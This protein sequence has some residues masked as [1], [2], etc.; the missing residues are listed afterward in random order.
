MSGRHGIPAGWTLSGNDEGAEVRT[1]AESEGRS[2]ITLSCG[3]MRGSVYFLTL[4][5]A[6]SARRHLSRSVE[7]S[8]SLSTDEVSGWAGLWMRVDGEV[9]EP[10]LAFD[11][12]RSRAL[13]G[14][15]PWT[16]CAVVLP[17]DPKARSIHFGLMLA[18][19]GCIRARGLSFRNTSAKSTD[20]HSSLPYEPIN[21]NFNL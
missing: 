6:I 8:A 19:Q 7:F 3:R 2:I 12:M 14:T 5:Q 1:T 16:R 10:A 9:G 20:I 21:L 18:G 11:N 17:V 13:A 15:T 4:M